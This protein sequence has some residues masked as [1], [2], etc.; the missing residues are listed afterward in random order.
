MVILGDHEK[1]WGIVTYPP[2]TDFET[3]MK[4]QTFNIDYDQQNIQHQQ[5]IV[6]K[7]LRFLMIQNA[8]WI[9]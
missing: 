9:G 4:N 6:K 2:H 3:R 5:N 1:E 7:F 8:F